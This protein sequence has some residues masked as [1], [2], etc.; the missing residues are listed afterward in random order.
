MLTPMPICV[1]SSRA[2]RALAALAAL[3]LAAPAAFA[4]NLV[5]VAKRLTAPV[6]DGG[7]GDAVYDSVAAPTP[8]RSAAEP[9]VRWV[10]SGTALF[11]C[12]TGLPRAAEGLTLLVGAAGGRAEPSAVPTYGFRVAR[13]GAVL[14]PE[15]AV[16]AEAGTTLPGGLAPTTAVAE[17]ADGSWGLELS[18][19]IELVGGYAR[20]ARL[21]LAA[22][23][24]R[25]G[26]VWTWGEQAAPALMAARP[27]VAL[28]PLYPQDVS[29][30]SAFVDGRGGYLVIPDAPEFHRPPLTFEAWVRVVDDDCGTVLGSGFE[31][32]YWIGVCKA[33]RFRTPGGTWTRE[34]QSTLGEGWH[35]VALSVS[36]D[37][38]E[39]LYVDGV[40]DLRVGWEPAH[41]EE[42]AVRGEQRSAPAAAPP[43]PLRIG[44]DAEAPEAQRDLHGYVSAVRI[45]RRVRSAEEIVRFARVEPTG[46]EP[47]LV[48]AWQ[49]ARGLRDL[50]GRR[51]AGLVGDA[52]LA[53]DSL[54][55]PAE[56]GGRAPAPTHVTP[57]RPARAPWNG[58][59]P[60]GPDSVTVDGMC[61]PA[62]YAGG[63]RIALEPLRISEISVL[64]T[65]EAF[66]LCAN[67]LFGVRDGGSALTLLLDPSGAGGAARD[68]REIEITVSSDGRVTPPAGASPTRDSAP[69]LSARV[70]GDSVLA[71]QEDVRPIDAEWWSAEVRIPA[72]AV[73]GYD[74]G[75]G[76]RR[77]ALLYRGRAAPGRRVPPDV[78]S[79]MTSSWPAAVDLSAPAT[80]GRVTLTDGAAETPTEIRR[81]RAGGLDPDEGD[82]YNACPTDA[83]S[84]S[85]YAYNSSKK[86]PAVSPGTNPFVWAS[87]TLTEL[88]VSPE[89]S[90]FV[91]D[92]HDLD[93]RMTPVVADRWLVLNN[94]DK[95]VL[96]TE[97]G[98]LP[99]KARPLPGDRVI[100]GGRWI[101]D[102]GHDPKTEI[103]PV[104]VFVT[105]RLE[106]RRVRPD[107]P[108][109]QVRV[110]RVSMNSNPG[111]FGYKFDGSFAFDAQLPGG[112]DVPQGAHPFAALVAGPSQP[113]YARNGSTVV[114]T[115]TPQPKGNQY[116]EVALGYLDGYSTGLATLYTVTFD[117]IDFLDDLDA[118]FP[119]CGP[120]D[121]LSDCGEWYMDA[122][123]NGV[124]AKLFADKRAWDE[125]NPFS[126]G[127]TFAVV[128][129]EL[130]L[131]VAG[132]EDDDPLAGDDIGQSRGTLWD[133]GSLAALCCGP[134]H[135]WTAPG[136]NYRFHF[137][138]VAGGGIPD[139]LPV[140]TH[141][142][143]TVRSAEEP[144]DNPVS[145]T[146][147]GTL[148]VP[149][150]GQPSAVTQ[151]PAWLLEAPLVKSGVH[152]L[153]ADDDYYSFALSDF[154][155]VTV[156]APGTGTPPVVT[157][158][159]VYNVPAWLQDVVGYKAATV[160]VGGTGGAGEAPYVL[161]VTR[162]YR[163]I[164][165]DWGEP[166]DGTADGRVVDLQTP[167][168][169]S[170][171]EPPKIV[172]PGYPTA[173]RRRLV[174][175]WAW[176]H[177]AGDVDRYDVRIPKAKLP[178]SF[179][180]PCKY[181][182]P[183]SLELR[184]DARI[185]GEGWA[186]DSAGAM[187]VVGLTS[188]FP[189]GHVRVQVTAPQ[190]TPRGVYRLDADWHDAVIMSPEQCS[191]RAAF[192]QALK[193]AAGT[194]V[195]ISFV[196]LPYPDP[197]VEIIQPVLEGG[198]AFGLLRLGQASALS[199]ETVSQEEGPVTVRVYD[200]NRVLVAEGAAPAGHAGGTRV[201]ASGLQP[202]ASYLIQIL[203]PQPASGTPTLG[204]SAVQW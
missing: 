18:L 99:P 1:V 12:A 139:V 28:G 115:V 96:E 8:A 104:P 56:F 57:A 27:A 135:T 77:I 190:G 122:N 167:D 157:P 106:T 156:E 87:G 89:D 204:V 52:S 151:H 43:G 44:S 154:A 69:P 20:A 197:A 187:V 170:Q 186:F 90:P 177:V 203:A 111:A 166:L 120:I 41:E 50:T 158:A 198:T 2:C 121:N 33:V 179:Q 81:A 126:L 174:M 73:P 140:A 108:M 193:D 45:W 164:K 175:P 67:V 16:G 7:C 138:V 181:N 74:S 161:R 155:D 42:R 97:S 36:P 83:P 152:L 21:T 29:A 180:L 183:A 92:S 31:H 196:P 82:Y 34:G 66:Y 78:E 147:L 173:E 84:T 131:H 142:Y 10:H 24:D 46:S 47:D 100:V 114:I 48:G 200:L 125:D 93:M 40:V 123:I 202:G 60:L 58:R 25:G 76:L 9:T 160:R 162:A 32:G 132:Y 185:V 117:Q 188:Q 64:A 98:K 105:E 134:A 178:G 65:S 184:A 35:H 169:Q 168:P 49:F 103:H 63:A 194:I 59:L 15:R 95:L 189:D 110:V 13:N 146:K 128:G 109:Q 19:P 144:N 159:T 11:A 68:G 129:S 91:H 14:G 127:T 149:G 26:V 192:E 171:V 118:G 3:L 94:G 102:C 38:E 163:T 55:V 51:D 39:V 153:G 116:W 80:W 148:T 4:T 133:V 6:V 137:T 5:T 53:R 30:G 130:W 191:A 85:T 17:G 61:R 199:L 62:E 113:T 141:D 124:G 101:F 136:S 201:F 37:G 71:L 195:P 86:W 107:K 172:P 182:Q 176:Q 88:Y 70:V 119:D 23:D 150:P 143:W 165:P 54:I 79:L 112:A 145:T 72:S 75:A 22:R